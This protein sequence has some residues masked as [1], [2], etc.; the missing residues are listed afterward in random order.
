[1]TAGTSTTV[2]QY[3]APRRRE[4][5]ALI[6]ARVKEAAPMNDDRNAPS[7]LPGLL[8]AARTRWPHRPNRRERFVAWLRRCWR[9]VWG[10]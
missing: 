2:S 8:R 9:K 6:A 4:V 3:V 5:A 10:R 7:R 1:M